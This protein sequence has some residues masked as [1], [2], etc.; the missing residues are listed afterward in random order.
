MTADEFAKLVPEDTR[1]QRFLVETYSVRIV[2]YTPPETS[3]GEDIMLRDAG[4]MRG[5]KT[6]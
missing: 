4:I 5:W 1:Q 3:I 2:P 6:P